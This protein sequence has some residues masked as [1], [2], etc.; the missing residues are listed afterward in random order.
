MRRRRLSGVGR[1]QH[2]GA[3]HRPGAWLTPTEIAFDL[4]NIERQPVFLV[5]VG[6][7][8]GKH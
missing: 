4:E 3:N 6:Y 2:L 5:G 8:T 7:R 1:F